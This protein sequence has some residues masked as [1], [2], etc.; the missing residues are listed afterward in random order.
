M[1]I[2]ITYKWNSDTLVLVWLC[3]IKIWEKKGKSCY[4]NTNIF[5]VYI[6]TE[7]I[8]VDIAKGVKTRFDTSN[9]ELE[10]PLPKGKNGNII[11]L[12]K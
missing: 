2:N 10:K 7:E 8:Y 12:I 9:F 1:S 4:M 5:I 11:E 3:E 6:K